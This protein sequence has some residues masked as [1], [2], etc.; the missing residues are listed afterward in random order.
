MV[1]V[2]DGRSVKVHSHRRDVHPQ[3]QGELEERQGKEGAQSRGTGRGEVNAFQLEGT[4]ER[5]TETGLEGGW[6]RGGVR[7]CG[8]K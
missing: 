4:K 7:S 2:I 3:N 1:P 6:G 5:R 8:E